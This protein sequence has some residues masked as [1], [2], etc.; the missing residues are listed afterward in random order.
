MDYKTHLQ[1]IA[2]HLKHVEAERQTIRSG[3]Q[4]DLEAGG[5]I[6]DFLDLSEKDPSF[7]EGITATMLRTFPYLATIS[8]T[9]KNLTLVLREGDKWLKRPD[10]IEKMSR[11]IPALADD[12]DQ[13][14]KTMTVV[15]NKKPKSKKAPVEELLR[16]KIVKGELLADSKT[17]T[18]YPDFFTALDTVLASR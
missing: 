9:G 1:S 11:Y 5:R 6:A 15:I 12:A 16:F 17:I 10:N 18:A 8:L 14:D 4:A 7:A 3:V 13:W 2:D